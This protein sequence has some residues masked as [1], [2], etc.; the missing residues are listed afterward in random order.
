MSVSIDATVTTIICREL[1]EA[2]MFT[3]SHLGAIWK[4]E[5]L[6]KERKWVYS[7]SETALLATIATSI[8]NAWGILRV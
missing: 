6:S 3:I 8:A 1:L 2:A 4:S 7:K 5:Q